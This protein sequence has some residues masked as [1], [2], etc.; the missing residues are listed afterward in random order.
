MDVLTITSKKN[1]I[2]IPTYYVPATT[3]ISIV[4]QIA[5]NYDK[6][7]FSSFKRIHMPNVVVMLVDIMGHEN[8]KTD[9]F[10]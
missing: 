8:L 9:F 6:P 1:K 5:F 10:L 3:I 2:S 7:H 4:G